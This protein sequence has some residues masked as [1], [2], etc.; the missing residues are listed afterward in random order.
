MP[1]EVTINCAEN[2]PVPRCEVPGHCWKDVTNID[3]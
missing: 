2:A 1:E 3:Y